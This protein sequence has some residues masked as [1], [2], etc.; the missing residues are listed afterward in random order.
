MVYPA[1]GFLFPGSSSNTTDICLPH[2]KGPVTDA[3]ADRQRESDV[4]LMLL[5]FGQTLLG[6]GGVPIQPFGISYIDDYA[7]ATNSPLYIGFIFAATALG[8]AIAFILGSF[9]LRFY[10]DIDK[11]SSA[12]VHIT[13][14][15]P[16][17]VG[18]W[19]LG[20]IF[21]ASMVA[22]ASIPYFFFPREMPKEVRTHRRTSKHRCPKASWG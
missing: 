17:W 1:S 22:I 2:R 10:V 12:E 19:W 3:C 15:D 8:P 7:S 18:A 13:N 4:V 11:V 5:L 16:R 20:F 6:I 21:A 14:K 9:M